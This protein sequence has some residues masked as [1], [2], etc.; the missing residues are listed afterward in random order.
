MRKLPP[1][2]K[3]N[4]GWARPASRNYPL[5]PLEEP[6]S[7]AVLR[8]QQILDDHVLTMELAGGEVGYVRRSSL[9]YAGGDFDMRTRRIASKAVPI[10]GIFS[11]QNL[12]A[13]RFEATSPTSLV[14]GRDYHGTVLG[15]EVTE[16]EAVWLQPALYL[17]HR[18]DLEFTVKRVARREFWTLTRVTGEGTVWIKAPGRSFRK[19]LDPETPVVVDT[20]YVAAVRGDFAADGRV[21]SRGQY[22]RSGEAENVK[23]RGMGDVLIQTE[24]PITAAGGGGPL[25][26]LLDLFI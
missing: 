23:I 19:P 18:G 15:M 1:L 9:I 21:F 6:G 4:R 11:G 7:S 16:G 13:N 8:Q 14:A 25:G 24:V 12:W 26:Y 17:G 2:Q 5:V 20:N 10:L 3:T 22:L